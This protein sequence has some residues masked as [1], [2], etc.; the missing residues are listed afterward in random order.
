MCWRSIVSVTSASRSG[1]AGW[2]ERSETHQ[3]ASG[4]DRPALAADKAGDGI[5]ATSLMGRARLPTLV[6]RTPSTIQDSKMT[7]WLIG[8]CMRRAPGG[9]LAL[10]S[11]R[12]VAKA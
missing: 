6:I 11:A 12:V 1:I 5:R 8:R 10:I 3:G 2:D 4:T 9:T 7:R